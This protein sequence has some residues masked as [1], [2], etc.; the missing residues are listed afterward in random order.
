MRRNDLSH[1]I[2]IRETFS[3]FPFELL[4]KEKHYVFSFRGKSH[5]RSKRFLAACLA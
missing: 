2:F 3:Y 1:S 4:D 5:N